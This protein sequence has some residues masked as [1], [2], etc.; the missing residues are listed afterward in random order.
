LAPSMVMTMSTVEFDR[1]GSTLAGR[2]SPPAGT[3]ATTSRRGLIG[4]ALRAGAGAS[5]AVL[6]VVVALILRVAH[7]LWVMPGALLG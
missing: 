3:A 1:I 6:L 5:I 4:R 2:I 7:M